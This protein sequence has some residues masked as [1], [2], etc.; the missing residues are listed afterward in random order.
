M[1]Q[2][3]IDTTKILLKE[4]F[5]FS[6]KLIRLKHRFSFVEMFTKV[7]AYALDGFDGLKHAYIVMVAFAKLYDV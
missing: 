6:I 2:N 7:E 3:L 1:N 4:A 5:V